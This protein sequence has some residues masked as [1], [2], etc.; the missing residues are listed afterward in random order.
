MKP[1]MN[2][3]ECA[4][5]PV[6]GVML[7]IVVTIIIA[8]VVSAFTTNETDLAKRAGPVTTLG[9][10]VESTPQ[11]LAYSISATWNT[12][13]QY[14]AEQDYA[15]ETAAQCGAGSPVST[16]CAAYLTS[17]NSR[18]STKTNGQVCTYTKNCYKGKGL[19][20]PSIKAWCP[21]STLTVGNL[22]YYN[23][24]A[25]GCAVPAQHYPE[26]Y[27]DP[28]TSESF[29]DNYDGILFTS[30]GGDPIDLKDLELTARYYDLTGSVKYSDT[31]SDVPPSIPDNAVSDSLTS[32]TVIKSKCLN[33]GSQGTCNR[34]TSTGS[35]DEY[36]ALAQKNRFFVKMNAFSSDDTII[37]PGDQ[38]RFYVD[39]YHQDSVYMTTPHIWDFGPMVANIRSK[40]TEWQ[41]IHA[42]SGNI[43]AHGLI[44]IHDT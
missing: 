27:D 2:Q 37:R 31:K 21:D 5:S 41:L 26:Y 19:T 13:D 9:W 22:T 35:L 1:F 25:N 20:S 17:I 30:E 3:N 11:D 24:A 4:I 33:P 34:L 18:D 36:N 39:H 8:A 6:I 7:M 29:W 16:I 10:Q 23:D 14:H 40:S 38:F 43:L 44:E 32:P 12:P 28:Y 42:P 15:G